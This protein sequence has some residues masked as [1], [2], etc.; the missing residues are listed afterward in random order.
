MLCLP[1]LLDGGPVFLPPRGVYHWHWG[2]ALM[3][4]EFPSQ[5]FSFLDKKHMLAAERFHGPPQIRF[6]PSTLMLVDSYLTLFSWLEL[7]APFLLFPLLW[8]IPLIYYCTY[9][10]TYQW[11]P[12]VQVFSYSNFSYLCSGPLG[13]RC[14][15]GLA[16]TIILALLSNVSHFII[17]ILIMKI[18]EVKFCY[19]SKIVIW[20]DE[21]KFCLPNVIHSPEDSES[22][23]KL[24]I[25]FGSLK[26]A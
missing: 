19:N 6:H 14:M 2:A 15:A 23:F 4:S 21:N 11:V 22:N 8:D 17:C 7:T 12:W 5:S 1:D 25:T 26:K 10:Q 3:I 18:P 16:Q 24:G 13:G 20:R 9:F